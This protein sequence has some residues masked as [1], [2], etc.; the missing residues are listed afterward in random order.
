MKNKNQ[1]DT[2]RRKEKSGSPQK[3]ALETQHK[4]RATA[5]KKD[6]PD[7]KKRQKKD[8]EINPKELTEPI[9]EKVKKKVPQRKNLGPSG[10]EW[11][12]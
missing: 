8:E 3:D 5:T 12:I 10:Q 4:S 1:L 2:D 7:S 6:T 11:D 9:T